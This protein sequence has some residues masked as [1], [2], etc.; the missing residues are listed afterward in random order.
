MSEG[1]IKIKNIVKKQNFNL[2]KV[3]VTLNS[4]SHWNC[5]ESVK[6]N[7]GHHHGKFGQI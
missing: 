1:L 5:H 2:S 7:G 3:A 4:T 6:F